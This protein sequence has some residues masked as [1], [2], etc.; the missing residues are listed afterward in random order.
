M[1][2]TPE[3]ANEQNY[4]SGA[5]EAGSNRGWPEQDASRLRLSG[6]GIAVVRA[7]SQSNSRVEV[8][9]DHVDEEVDEDKRRREEEHR[10]LHH[11]IVAVVDRLDRQA[12]DTRPGEDRLGD[13][14]AP[15]QRAELD[16]DDGHDR[17]RG[18]LEGVLPD[19]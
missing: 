12:A 9:V 3:A 14:G 13:D 6:H 8:G 7:S 4:W 10:R 15:E 11:R 2:S 5:H 17:D 19:D 18:V 16:P 1:P